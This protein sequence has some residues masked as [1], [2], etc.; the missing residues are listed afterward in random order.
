MLVLKNFLKRL[1][2]PKLRHLSR[3]TPAFQV[4]PFTIADVGSTGGLDPRWAPL[5]GLSQVYAFD[6]D[7][8]ALA[9]NHPRTYVLPHGLWSSRAT[10]TL[11][12]TR[13]APASSVF[14]PNSALLDSFLNARSHEVMAVESI[15]VQTMESSL[16]GKLPPHFIKVDAEGADLDILQGAQSFLGSSCVGVQVEVQFLERNKGSP[17]FGQTDR[18]L[19]DLGF[20]L[21][22][23]QREFWIR[24]NGR[25]APGSQAQL[26]WADAVYLL[27]IPTAIARARPL[28]ARERNEVLTQLVVA[29][30]VY[31]AH[32]YALEA[33][34]SFQADGLVGADEARNLCA[35]VLANIETALGLVLRRSVH[36]LIALL[37]LCASVAW[38]RHRAGAF[39][40]FRA[41]AARLFHSL[42]LCCARAGESRGVVADVQV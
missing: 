9:G 7:Q 33:I 18:F 10:L 34:E 24:R 21:L 29:A 8:R 6:P 5:E 2:Q 41:S 40:F 3:V 13:F 39:Q 27:S 12:L 19:Q 28:A 35:F 42:H 15:E 37:V 4:V 14:S 31:G 30:V 17:L 11:H 22:T 23:L 26:V 16:A 20:V 1:V 32:D 36:L 25:W 38:P